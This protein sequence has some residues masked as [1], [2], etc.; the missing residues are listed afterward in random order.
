MRKQE[1]KI[2][3]K[4]RK[5]TFIVVLATFLVVGYA[6]FAQPL[7]YNNAIKVFKKIQETFNF[8]NNSD[9]NKINGEQKPSSI[10]GNNVDNNSSLDDIIST[11]PEK[12]NIKFTKAV[13]TAVCG[14][15]REIS[16]VKFEA[17]SASFDVVLTGPGDE[18]SYAFTIT[19]GGVIKAKIDEIIVVPENNDNSVIAYDISGIEL[20]DRLLPGESIDMKVKIYYNDKVDKD[21]KY[22]NDTLKVVVNFA[23][24]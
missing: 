15:A 12:W 22:Y 4:K 20:D 19:N 5:V 1:K 18:I 7:A 17:L 8:N 6:T 21:I 10:A 16:A 14:N 9:N 11:T 13:K 24:D 2:V 23:Q 3:D